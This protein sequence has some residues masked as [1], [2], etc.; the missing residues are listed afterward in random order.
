MTT[1][2]IK[3]SSTASAAPVAGDLTKGELAVN[4]TDKKL[5]TK[6]NGGSVVKLVGSLGNQESNAVAVTGGA[7]DGTPIG[8]TTASTASFTTVSASGNVTLSGGTANGV[9][10]LNGSKVATSGSALTFDGTNFANTAGNI[11]SGTNVRVGIGINTGQIYFNNTDVG[12]WRGAANSLSTGAY[13]NLGGYDGIAFATSAAGIGSQSEGMR[14]TSTGLGIGTSSPVV[15]FQVKD[16]TNYNFWVRQNSSALQ[17]AAATDANALTV[18]MA[19]SAGSYS[20]AVNNGT[21]ALNLD[22]SGNLGLG[23]TPSASTLRMIQGP[24]AE[25][26]FSGVYPYIAANTYYNS[27][28][29]YQTSAAASYYVQATGQHQ[30]F[31]APSGTA[32]NAITFTQAM[33]LDASGRLG[34]G[35]TSPVERLDISGNVQIRAS[36]ILNLNNSDSSNQF[37]LQNTGST[38]GNNANLIFQKT[39]YGEVARI[40][41]SGNLLVGTT[42]NKGL[43]ITAESTSN[44]IWATCTVSGQSALVVQNA[45]GGGVSLVAFQTGS[46]TGTNVGSIYYS[47]GL[48]VYATTSDYRLKNVIG[49]VTGA[50]ARIDALEPVEYEWKSSGERTRGFLAHKFQEVYPQSVSGEKDAVDENGNPKYQHMQASTSEVIADLVAEIKSLRARVAQLESN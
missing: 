37:Y 4:V 50:G 11:Q 8:G 38:G 9:L 40:D 21:N 44:T 14:L 46:G 45:N 10:Y 41:S 47:A 43:G 3:N 23:V 36:G 18:P 49:E 31:T 24:N 30:W 29:K 39:N 28:W 17:L 7:I 13:L 32:G 5:Y 12:V 27:G 26:V 19:F 16:G 33:T 42:S 25:F 6:D 20:W 15:K 48:T 34:L 1:I 22:S 2:I 35:V